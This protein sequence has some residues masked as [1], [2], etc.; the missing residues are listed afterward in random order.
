[1]GGVFLGLETLVEKRS[2]MMSR[3]T[4]PICMPVNVPLAGRVTP[5]KTANEVA[6]AM[7][8][9]G[10]R[11]GSLWRSASLAAAFAVGLYGWSQHSATVYAA[12][13]S[14]MAR[15]Q[16]DSKSQEDDDAKAKSAK[17]STKGP[18]KSSEKKAAS[19]G[20]KDKKKASESVE[21]DAAA[22]DL[23][24]S[25]EAK[26]AES[27]KRG[28]RLPRYY[29]KLGLADDQRA[30]VL[31]LQEQFDAQELQLR[32]QLE[33][34][35]QQRE[36]ELSELLT[37]VQREQLQSLVEARAAARKAGGATDEVSVELK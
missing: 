8:S 7:A 22:E 14:A 13:P 26:S 27:K 1:M 30:Q 25:S 16:E 5:R 34:L 3:K 15:M 24:V 21:G 20:A 11:A 33:S 9:G 36:R 37:D 2:Q 29:S 6:S 28:P 4:T 18:M 31:T 23:Q 10:R 32:E 35:A 12:G 17:G 19:T